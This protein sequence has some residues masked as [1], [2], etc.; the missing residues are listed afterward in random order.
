MVARKLIVFF[1]VV[2]FPLGLLGLSLAAG[3][4]EL[5]GTVT[6][7]E[8]GIVSIKDSVGEKM[9]KPENPEALK[10]LKVGDE[11]SVKDGKLIKE[12][13]AGPS[14]PSPGPKY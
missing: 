13:G 3:V 12:G 11:V 8:G 7:I 9:I 1:V 5:K 2:M 6:K 10:D 4:D 14:A